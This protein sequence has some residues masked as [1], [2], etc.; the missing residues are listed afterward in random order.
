M[1]IRRYSYTDT[2]TLGI[3]FIN[4]VYICDTLEL[5]WKDNQRNISC[6]PEGLYDINYN[7]SPKHGDSVH[8][9]EVPGRA[10]ILIHAG[11][12]TKDTEG[13]IL[14]GTKNRNMLVDSRKA[15]KQVLEILDD[16]LVI[17]RI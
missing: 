9:K 7:K 8:V 1:L 14:V 6:V 10:G 11:N 15:L 4:D 2:E 13:C 12:T 17:E 16:V 3:L 5:P